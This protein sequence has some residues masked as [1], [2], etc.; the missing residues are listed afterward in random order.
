MLPWIAGAIIIGVGTYLLDDAK[1]EN[2]RARDNYDDEYDNSVRR[3]EREAYHAKRKDTLDKL[4]KI[5][6]AK[7]KIAD[8]VYG[9]LKSEEQGL[10]KLRKDIF[11]SKKILG[12]LFDEKHQSFSKEEKREIQGRINLIIASRKELFLIEEEMINRLK[13]LR[14]ELKKANQETK[15][16]QDEI[17]QV[18]EN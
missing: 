3:L 7:K 8:E 13:V 16:V 11:D 4:F 2:S 5:K 9:L 17:N 6:R 12:K 10:K 15:M 1:S 14:V 18:L